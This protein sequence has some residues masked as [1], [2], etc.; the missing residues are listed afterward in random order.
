MIVPGEASVYLPSVRCSACSLAIAE[1]GRSFVFQ[2][3]VL[4]VGYL[5]KWEAVQQDDSGAGWE[6]ERQCRSVAV[7]RAGA[8]AKEVRAC[9]EFDAAVGGI[10]VILHGKG[11]TGSGP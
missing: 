2:S 1:G 10:G 7:A 6:R 8:P 11:G 5:P 4:L 3:W 9:E